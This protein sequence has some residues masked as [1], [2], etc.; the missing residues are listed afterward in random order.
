MLRHYDLPSEFNGL[1]VDYVQRVSSDEYSSSCPQCG[2]VPHKGGELPDRF[3]LFLNA[4][5]KNKVMGWCRRCSYVWFPDT[6]R[7]IA[8]EEMERWRK[9]QLEREEARKRSAEKA[10]SALQSEKIWLKFHEALNAYSLEVLR[11][12][13]IHED[14]ARYWRLG[15]LPDYIVKTKDEEY[16]SPAISIPLWQ[17]GS[18]APGNV[19]LRILNP[20]NSGD[21]YR[22]FYKT[23]K[24]FDFTAF[25]QLKSDTVVIVEGEKKAMVVAQWSEQKYQVVGLP[26]VT[27]NNDLLAKYDRYGKVIVCLDPDAKVEDGNGH[28][29][30]KRLVKALGREVAWVDLPDKVD[31][32]IL[33]GMRF[34]NALKYS[35]ALEVK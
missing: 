31:D 6:V 22:S 7:P 13:G 27:P 3:R 4:S 34:D 2:G 14:W 21:R 23:G 11:S 9:E 28:S 5:G 30:L 15:L 18:S 32:M 24:T 19:K 25:N 33:R 26:S 12:W 17:Y 1:K 20:K 8:P 29:P 35:K 10:I 16:H